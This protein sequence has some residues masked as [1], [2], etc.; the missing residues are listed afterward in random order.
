MLSFNHVTFQYEGD[1][2][3]ILEDLSFDIPKEAFISLIGVSGTGKSTIFRLTNQLLK[4]DQGDICIDG[5]PVS[6]RKSPVGYMPQKDLLFP[7]RTVEK[8]LW[9]PMEIQKLPK[10]IMRQKADAILQ[11][12]GLDTYKTKYPKDLSGGMRQRISFARTLLT[13]A[14]LLLL[15][16]PFSA[17]DSLTRMTMQEW[18]LAQWAH[19][20]KTILFITHD[21]E[22]ALLLSQKVLVITCTPIKTLEVIEVPAEYPRTR[23]CLTRPEMVALKE[24]LIARLR[25]Q[26]YTL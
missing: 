7:W 16:E 9:L 23:E 20:H 15:D 25:E 21:V 26:V 10:E 14:D 12:I 2:R 13:Q 22:E 24:I 17:L 19:F 18:L 3:P 5:Q 8:N 6:A 4:P 11:D 1:T